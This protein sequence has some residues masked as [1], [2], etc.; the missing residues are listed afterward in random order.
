MSGCFKAAQLAAASVNLQIGKGISGQHQKVVIGLLQCCCL[1]KTGESQTGGCGG[2]AFPLHALQGGQ[3]LSGG[4]L[5][6]RFLNS[7]GFAGLQI[8]GHGARQSFLLG[9][10]QAVGQDH[11]HDGGVAGILAQIQNHIHRGISADAYLLIGVDRLV[12]CDVAVHLSYLSQLLHQS[13]K[14]SVLV[15]QNLQSY[16]PTEDVLSRQNIRRQV[17][18]LLLPPHLN[19]PGCGLHGVGL[20]LAIHGHGRADGFKVGQSCNQIVGKA[21]NA[22]GLQNTEKLVHIFSVALSLGQRQQILH[23]YV[24]NRIGIHRQAGTGVM[25]Q[26]QIVGNFQRHAPDGRHAF[27]LQNISVYRQCVISVFVLQP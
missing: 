7:F 24:V 1:F 10:L 11:S 17:V 16:G 6:H 26:K 23:R 5:L 2:K 25:L 4:Y 27:K 3:Q 8:S 22:V 19:R 21:G 15:V 20:D 12:Q 18:A 9:A 14:V 13:G